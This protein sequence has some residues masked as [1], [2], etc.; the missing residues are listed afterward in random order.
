MISKPNN[1]CEEIARALDPEHIAPTA[2]F[3]AKD[4]IYEEA[5]LPLYSYKHKE[6]EPKSGL[7]AWNAAPKSRGSTKLR[8]LNE[9][10]IP[11]PR[12]FHKR[13]PHFFINNIFDFEETQSSYKGAKE[14][15]PEIRFKLVLPNGKTI[16]ALITQERHKAFQSGSRTEIDPLT[17][18]PY[19]QSALGQWLLVDVLGLDERVPVTRDWLIKKDVDSVRIWHEKG[20]YSTYYIDIAPVNSFENFMENEVSDNI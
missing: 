14:N 10:Y 3:I 13:Y 17:G 2:S 1:V 19:G 6:V 5:Y 18:N 4:T 9:V 7:N 11:I 16:P 8:P 20:D 15:K 12:E